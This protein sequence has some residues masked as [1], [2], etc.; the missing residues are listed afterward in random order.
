MQDS[1]RKLI[2]RTT[3]WTAGVG[4]VLSPIPLLDEL[5]LF[6]MYNVL[7]YRIA[8]RHSLKWGQMPW[9]PILR[10]T[11]AGLVARAAVNI[12]VALLPG[13]SAVGSA[14]TAAA[15]TEILGTYIDAA[16]AD[17]AAASTLTVK[18]VFGLLKAQVL[19]KKQDKDAAKAA[20]SS[21]NGVAHPA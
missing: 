8:R 20:S 18:D 16:C 4:V 13:V 10:S 7:S 12:T 19:R 9:R 3:A 2:H 6:P 11:T 5:A 14:A 17:P 15:L 21:S 1:V